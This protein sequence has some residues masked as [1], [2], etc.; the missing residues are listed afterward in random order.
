MAC[1]V[2]RLPG[3]R[4]SSACH[5]NMPD[6]VGREMCHKGTVWGE[7]AHG[8]NDTTQSSHLMNALVPETGE[9]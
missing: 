9:V 5:P 4:T 3:A 6:L 1:V 7:A 2:T 8:A